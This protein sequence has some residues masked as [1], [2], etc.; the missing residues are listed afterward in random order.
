[1]PFGFNRKKDPPAAAASEPSEAAAPADP[2]SS[3]TTTADSS[4]QP[5]ADEPAVAQAAPQAPT[6][7][8]V[9]IDQKHR[10][11]ESYAAMITPSI[12]LNGNN[13]VL[14]DDNWHLETTEVGSL[15]AEV[16]AL[17]ATVAK[18]DAEIAEIKGEK[19]GGDRHVNALKFKQEV[20]LD[21]LAVAN[22]DEKT[23]RLRYEKERIKVDEYRKRLE[24]LV[25]LCAK[26]NVSV[27]EVLGI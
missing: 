3:T 19:G 11:D 23:A 13:L 22:A 20:L 16:A 6:D 15:L 25:G 24:A 10:L 7:K 1:M 21:M 27:D 2:S 4:P 17:K 14:S 8:I 9:H 26:H 5:A 12:T 18:K